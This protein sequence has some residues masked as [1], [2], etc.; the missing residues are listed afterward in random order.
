M[1]QRWVDLLFLH[2]SCDPGWIQDLLPEGLKLDL[3]EGK[4]WIGVVP[5]QMKNVRFRGTPAIPGISNFNEL[6]VRTYV[7]DSKGRPGVWF[8]SLDTDSRLAAWLGRGLF[9]LN[10]FSAKI[11]FERTGKKI[12]WHACRRGE[13]FSDKMGH[14]IREDLPEAVP[15]SIEFFLLER[16]HYFVGQGRRLQIGQVHHR[17][18]P[19]AVAD[20]AHWYQGPMVWNG[21]QQFPKPPDHMICSSGVDVEIFKA[22][23]V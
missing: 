8:I 20:V 3:W 12:T 1:Y 7:H 2:W 21:M 5:F 17:P 22:E 13:K 6:N 23:A 14:R 19:L 16:Y 18:Y 11:D 10:Y 9:G 15:G 4:A